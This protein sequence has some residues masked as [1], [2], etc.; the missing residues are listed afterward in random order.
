MKMRKFASLLLALVLVFSLASTAFAEVGKVDSTDALDYPAANETMTLVIDNAQVGAEVNLYKLLDLV[1]FDVDYD[2]DPNTAGIQPNVRYEA[3]TDKE[4]VNADGETVTISNRDDLTWADFF[5]F[6]DGAGNTVIDGVYVNIDA[7]KHVSWISGADVAYFS[8][9]ALNY[10]LGY[11]QNLDQG[12]WNA[13][14]NPHK[15]VTVTAAKEGDTIAVLNVTGLTP[16]YYLLSSSMGNNTI[17][18]N[19]IPQYDSASNTWV[20]TVEIIGK[21]S[22]TTVEKE[23][24]EDSDGSWGDTNDAD[25]GQTVNFASYIVAETGYPDNDQ[26][27]A[28]G[29]IYMDLMDEG[30]TLDM[31]SIK[32]YYSA[33]TLSVGGDPA[34]LTYPESAVT[35]ADGGVLAVNDHYTLT[36]PAETGAECKGDPKCTFHVI[37]DQKWL[38]GIKANRVIKITYSAVINENAIVIDP[39]TGEPEIDPLTNAGRLRYGR[40]GSHFTEWDYTQT[41]VWEFNVLKFDAGD[42]SIVLEGAEFILYK[43]VGKDTDGNPINSYAIFTPVY[44]TDASGNATTVVDYYVFNNWTDDETEAT[45]LVTGADGKIQIL[46]L[47]ADKAGTTYYLLETKAPAGYNLLTTPVEVVLTAK[48]GTGS[49]GDVVVPL[50]CT[51]SVDTIEMV[52]KTVKVANKQGLE[53]PE[54]GGMGT[55]MFYW[56]GGLLT[57]AAAVLLITRRRLAA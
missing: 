35:Y 56:V 51:V 17:L 32:V 50:E 19:V 29:Y 12:S 14:L 7:D 31:N 15:T 8:D 24:E 55:T 43:E 46:G 13:R 45:D 39:V 16:G 52:D 18:V 28:I 11:V 9:L 44:E 27:G 4:Y 53:L 47:D 42:E 20:N 25:V 10:A 5:G 2:I 57:L 34:T 21:N 37:F 40:D 54:T 23:V 33:E 3:N 30:L 38:D 26:L 1:H 41:Y 22:T 36:F 48:E 49:T 6:V